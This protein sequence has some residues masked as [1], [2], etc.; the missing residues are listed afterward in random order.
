MLYYIKTNNFYW[1]TPTLIYFKL[2]YFI[3][4]I[5]TLPVHVHHKP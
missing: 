3:L 4:R 5:V 2:L 1:R